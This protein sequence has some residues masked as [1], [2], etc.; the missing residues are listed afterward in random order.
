MSP[1]ALV[2]G[3]A[4]ARLRDSSPSHVGPAETSTTRATPSGMSRA[5]SVANTWAST[6]ST[7]NVGGVHTT[8]LAGAASSVTGPSSSTTLSACMREWTFSMTERE[9]AIRSSDRSTE[10]ANVLTIGQAGLALG[11]EA[12]EAVGAE[13]GQH[14]RRHQQAQ[15][16]DLPHQQHDRQAEGGVERRGPADARQEA[17]PSSGGPATRRPARHRRCRPWRRGRRRGARPSVRRRPANP[18]GRRRRS[19]A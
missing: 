13:A 17:G 2:I 15:V 7:E 6:A 8:R 9:M 3:A 5:M 4:M 14:D 10:A 12:V 18:A 1:L 11:Q 16:G 19:P